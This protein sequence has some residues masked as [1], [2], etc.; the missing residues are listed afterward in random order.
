MTTAEKEKIVHSWPFPFPE[1]LELLGWSRDEKLKSPGRT[2]DEKRNIEA[3]Y[4]EKLNRMLG[5]T[6]N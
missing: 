6:P 4:E 3:E 2:E 1:Y 5:E